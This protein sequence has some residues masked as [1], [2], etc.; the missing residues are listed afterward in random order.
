[1]IDFK[2][3]VLLLTGAAGGIG[4]ATATLFAEAGASLVLGDLDVERVT[5]AVAGLDLP[6]ERLAIAAH[7]ATDPASAQALVALAQERFGG[8]DVVVPGAGIYPT[9]AF[10]TM[11]AATWSQALAVNL[12]GVFHLCQAALPALRPEA[13]I[14][15]IASMAAH[16]GSPQHAHYAAAKGAVLSLARSLAKELAPAVRVNAVSPGLIDTPMVTPLLAARGP[17]LLA[18]TPL[19]RLGTPRDVAGC[20]A[21]LASPLAGFVT[22]ATLQVNGGLYIAG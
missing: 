15:M 17:A 20:I 1:M 7:D 10:A 6:A 21:F 13:A 3:K 11:P 9:D 4:L 18:A 8:V 16:Y 14:V 19:G 12:D 2:G 5:A 22:G